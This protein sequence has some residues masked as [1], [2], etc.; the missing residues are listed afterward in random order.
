MGSI[1]AVCV[2]R[3]LHADVGNRSGQTAI[4]KAPVGGPVAVGALG[5]A[6]DRQMD[7]DHHGGRQQAVYA[8]AAE[9]AAW[10]ADRL[11]R[12]VP[13]GHFGENLR[14]KGLDVTGAVIGE[15]WQIGGDDGVLLEVTCPRIPCSTFQRWMGEPHWVKRFTEHGAPGA[16]L[17]V[18]AEGR[19]RA[20]D[21]VE[22]VRRPE[23]KVTIGDCFP[24]VGGDPARRLLLAHEA[25]EVAVD[26]ELLSWAEAAAARPPG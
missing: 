26:P 3:A 20:G 4:D 16:Y 22:I 11:R 10:W 19:V 9:D 14:T 12:D 21:R 2:V 23:H 13:P 8:Y 17:K 24:R 15:Q 7:A 6:G 25:G 1:E 5:L 18:L